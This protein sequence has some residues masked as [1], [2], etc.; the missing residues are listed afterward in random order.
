MIKTISTDF[1][2]QVLSGRTERASVSERTSKAN[3]KG[4]ERNASCKE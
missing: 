1:S 4:E 2:P 3:E